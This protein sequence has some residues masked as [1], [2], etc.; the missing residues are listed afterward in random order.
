MSEFK[1]SLGFDIEENSKAKIQDIIDEINA[2]KPEITIKVN[3]EQALKDIKT[4]QKELKK[5]KDINIK[6]NTKTNQS[7]TRN[8][9]T[10]TNANESVTK[11][12]LSTNVNKVSWKKV[13]KNTNSKSSFN[14]DADDVEKLKIEIEQATIAYSKM[15]KI[16][17]ELLFLTLAISSP[18][19]LL[20]VF[21]NYIKNPLKSQYI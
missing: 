3:T 12:Q 14:S 6:I 19:F 16:A 2:K 17:K 9:N 11:N 13:D 10:N 15:L 20:R 8:K 18:T 21:L 7:G 4:L 5:L 1:I